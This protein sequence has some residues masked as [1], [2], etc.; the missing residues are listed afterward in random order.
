V[1]QFGAL[2]LEHQEALARAR[3]L[4]AY[5]NGAGLA[6]AAWATD[7]GGQPAEARQVRADLDRGLALLIGSL[8]GPARA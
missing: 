4:G 7:P 8:A 6:L 1:A 2:G 5:L 3:V